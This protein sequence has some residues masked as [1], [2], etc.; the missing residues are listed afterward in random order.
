[1]PDN[2]YPDLSLG[3]PDT[4]VRLVAQGPN[5]WRVRM[6]F[7]RAKATEIP[8]QL[9]K[10]KAELA[11]SFGVADHRLEYIGLISKRI[12]R[13][14]ILVEMQI[15]R[16]EVPSGDIRIRFTPMTATDGTEFSGMRAAIDL[17]PSDDFEQ[18]LTF[19]SVEEKIKAEGL[20]LG[21]VRWVLVRELIDNC[22]ANQTPLFDQIIAEGVLPDVGTSAQLFYRWHPHNDPIG[23][24]AWMGLRYVEAG[25][26]LVELSFPSTGLKAGRNVLGK[27]LSPRRGAT[28]RLEAGQGVALS[29]TERKLNARVSGLLVLHRHYHDRRQKDSPC[30]IPTMLTAEVV[31]IRSVLSEKAQNEKWEESIWVNGSLDESSRL[32]VNGDCIING[33][34]ANG[35]QLNVIGSLRVMGNVGEATLE[36]LH[37]LCVH[38][39]MNASMCEIGLTAQIMGE[40][41]D[42]TIFAR[43]ILAEQL[44]GGVAEAYAP[45]ASNNVLVHFNREKLLAERKTA[46]EDAM[47]TLRK[48]LSKLSEIFG[49]EILHQVTPDSVQIH[50]LRWLRFQK[51][52]GSPNFTHPQVQELRTLLELVPMLR[53]QMASVAGELRASDPIHP[54]S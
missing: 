26:D 1:M 45:V 37:H 40:A 2:H 49:P 15:R 4:K 44:V 19:A 8:E 14:G 39:D 48:Q 18:T 28:S 6:L 54:V 34:I 11:H 46:G 20:D 50:L 31:K 42:C 30:D 17:F 43:E 41:T 38:G 10:I 52:I 29:S 51:S 16:H 7:P 9:R 23:A 5:L 21:S 36:V 13:V 53:A 27:E 25:E 47:L 33:D 32:T 35:C 24:T 22:V 12:T 3:D